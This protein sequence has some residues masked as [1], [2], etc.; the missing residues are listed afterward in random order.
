MGGTL[1]MR[2]TSAAFP[3]GVAPPGLARSGIP[4]PWGWSCEGRLPFAGPHLLPAC[5]GM[6]PRLAGLSRTGSSIPRARGDGPTTVMLRRDNASCS[7]H[8]QGW[9]PEHPGGP[10]AV[11]LLPA[12]VGMV[13]RHRFEEGAGGVAPHTCGDGPSVTPGTSV[14]AGCSSPLR[15]WPLEELG[16][17]RVV[18][19][20][21]VLAGVVPGL[22]ARSSRRPSASRMR[23]DGLR[24]PRP[25]LARPLLPAPVR[26]IPPACRGSGAPGS[27][28]R[29]CGDGP[30][31]AFGSDNGLFCSPCPRGWPRPLCVR[32]PG[33]GLLPA[34]AGMVPPAS[35]WSAATPSAPRSRGDGLEV[36]VYVPP[37]WAAAPQTPGG[38]SFPGRRALHRRHLLPAPVGMVLTVSL[39]GSAS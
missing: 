13:S 25:E 8:L 33:P 12:S 9:P 19:L 31:T 17:Q 6:V 18:P 4:I 38:W 1:F 22:G 26:M 34:S 39:S 2:G 36:G 20:L 37:G 35:P 30:A 29:P 11:Q 15:G 24:T 32:G 21:P 5:A 7:P 27:A 3:A 14:H 23:G 28:P 10:R 16:L